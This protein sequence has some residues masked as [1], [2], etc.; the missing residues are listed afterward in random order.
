MVNH[1]VPFGKIDRCQIT[2]SKKLNLIIDLGCDPLL[3][4]SMLSLQ[5]TTCPLRLY[6][7][8]DSG[9]AQLDYIV[10]GY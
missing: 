10:D 9:L 2:G 1:D 4:E 6:Y 5:E 8:P 3:T 7:C